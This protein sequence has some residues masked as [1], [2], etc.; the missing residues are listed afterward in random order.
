MNKCRISEFREYVCSRYFGDCCDFA[1]YN[2]YNICV[3]MVKNKRLAS[4]GDV[5]LCIDAKKDAVAKINNW[6][7]SQINILN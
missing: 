3:H 6:L 2:N 1:I 5:C 7:A 4:I